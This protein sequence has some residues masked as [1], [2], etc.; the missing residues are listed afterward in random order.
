MKKI[1]ILHMPVTNSGSG[2]SQYIL[3]NWTFIDQSRFRFDF[4]TRS[5]SLDFKDEF[6]ALG[7]KI[8]HLSCSSD[9]NEAQFIKEV[10]QI[11]DEDYDAIHLHTSYWKGFLVEELAIK[12]NCPRII[13]HSHSTM[14]DIYDEQQR[15]AAVK[16][17]QYY[18]DRFHVGLGT[19]FTGCSAQAAN[20]LFG[21]QIPD[22]RIRILHNAIN[23]PKYS[24]S[25]T[26]RDLYREKL[27]LN[28][29]FVL[30]HVGRFAYQKNHEM[31][32]DVFSEVRKQ[33]P[34]V[35]LL[36]VGTGPL[37]GKIRQNVEHLGLERD[38]LFL[39]KRSDVPQLLQTMDMFLLPSHF[40]GLGLVLIEAQAAGLQCLASSE[41]PREAKVTSNLEFLPLSQ[42]LWVNRIMK[43]VEGYDRINTDELIKQA[44]YDLKDQINIIEKL[45]SGE[46][47]SKVCPS[48][49]D[50]KNF[51]NAK[52]Q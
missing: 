41:I 40:E 39:G 3:Q 37:E 34:H 49:A 50:Y 17:H 8:H 36:L 25:Q 5:N 4:A 24:F 44:G 11:L 26:T 21:D 1:K 42:P 12:R 47:I 30:G 22:D 7:S 20:W 10:N 19:D 32:I 45:Y 6:A 15:L 48:A 51:L 35:K 18:R 46:D 23:L 38:V 9:E 31:L 29:H 33:V 13:V 2:V 16:R 43:T 14:V 27:E 52:Q 28:H